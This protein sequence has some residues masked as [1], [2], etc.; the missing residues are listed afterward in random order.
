[1][2]TPP[3]SY[4][5]P[6]SINAAALAAWLPATAAARFSVVGADDWAVSALGGLDRGIRINAGTGCGDGIMDVTA[7]YET[8][9]LPLVASGSQWFLVVRRRNWATPAT[10]SLAIIPGTSEKKLP[11]RS[12]T[13]GQESDQPL[14]LCRVQD[15]QTLVQEII[16]LRCWAGNGGVVVADLLARDYLARPG[17]DLLCGSTSYRYTMGANGVWSW[18]DQSSTLVKSAPL[19]GAVRPSWAPLRTFNGVIDASSGAGGENRTATWATDAGGVGGLWFGYN[20]LPTFQGIYSVQL[21]GYHPLVAFMHLP[22]LMTVS[23]S[24]IKFKARRLDNSGWAN[25]YGQIS[26]AVAVTGW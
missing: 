8:L 1:M 6:G 11:D 7:E 9:S 15:G 22:S 26:M 18:I 5:Y 19:A 24:R 16:D 20:G 3:V 25:N 23:T 4:G 14:A 21:T 12:D 13:P 17:A 2:A 10:T